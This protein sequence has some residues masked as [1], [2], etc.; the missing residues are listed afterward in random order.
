MLYET[1]SEYGEDII[2]EYSK[3][4]MIE[5]GKKYNEI[6]LRSMRQMYLTPDFDIWKPPVSKLNWTHCLVLLS[7]KDKNKRDY[8]I[9]QVVSRRLSKRTLQEIMSL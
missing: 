6:T 5:V 9:N 7:I 4:L 3:K 1:G 2:G 8:Y